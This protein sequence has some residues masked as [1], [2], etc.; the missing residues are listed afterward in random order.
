LNR[1]NHRQ[2]KPEKTLKNK[3]RIQVYNKLIFQESHSKI[4][5]RT[6]LLPIKMSQSLAESQA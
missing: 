1:K 5:Y 4:T 6:R 3:K 2:I